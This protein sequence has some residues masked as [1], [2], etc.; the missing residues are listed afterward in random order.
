MS[1]S[2]EIIWHKKQCPICK[3]PTG[4][5]SNCHK[6]KLSINNDDDENGNSEYNFVSKTID[7]NNQ[8]Y[9][10]FS[11]QCYFKKY[12][13]YILEL[14]KPISA[15]LVTHLK[16]VDGVERI[17]VESKYQ[18]I[19]AIGNVFDE[20]EVKASIKYTIESVFNESEEQYNE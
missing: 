19:I 7:I 9:P 4:P 12:N 10:I 13:E 3:Q 2:V 8:L 14:N 1:N 6:I 18:M 17:D 11:D 15:I 16:H 5:E 20:E